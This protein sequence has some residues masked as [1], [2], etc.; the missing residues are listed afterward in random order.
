MR[1]HRLCSKILVLF[2]LE[3]STNAF[4]SPSRKV[5]PIKSE[6]PPTAEPFVNDGSFSPMVQ[7]LEMGG[8]KE[9]KTTFLGPPIPVDETKFPTDEKSNEMRLMAEKSMTN[10]GMEERE[11]RISAGN[12]ALIVAA[13]YAVWASIVD[14]DDFIGHLTRLGVFIPLAFGSG[15]RKSGEAGL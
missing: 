1:F 10:I 7:F 9:G 6:Q 8:F 15:Y 3:D 14:E 4:S 12:F 2:L 11:R 5:K 13:I